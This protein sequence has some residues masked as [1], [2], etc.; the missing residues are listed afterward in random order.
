MRWARGPHGG[1]AGPGSIWRR[2]EKTT[3][4]LYSRGGRDAAAVA[5]SFSGE[6]FSS[7]GLRREE[8]TTPKTNGEFNWPHRSTN[9]KSCQASRKTTAGDRIDCIMRAAILLSDR[10]LFMP[11][12]SRP[13]TPDV[14]SF[15][16]NDKCAPAQSIIR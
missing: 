5:A 7:H 15:T 8:T 12:S 3:S 4:I 16:R 2:R 10:V 1:H 14:R 11:R 13:S 6:K 9:W